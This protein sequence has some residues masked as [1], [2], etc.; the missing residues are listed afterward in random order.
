MNVHSVHVDYNVYPVYILHVHADAHTFDG[1]GL[2]RV[3]SQQHSEGQ[4]TLKR[5]RLGQQ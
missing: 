5:V 3:E 2:A 1:N 4:M